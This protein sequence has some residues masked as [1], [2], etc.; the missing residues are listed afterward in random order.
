M[1]TERQK[2]EEQYPKTFKITATIRAPEYAT[3]EHVRAV[4]RFGLSALKIEKIEEVLDKDL[5]KDKG[6]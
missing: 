6:E 1:K 2:L 4:I 5:E 3:E